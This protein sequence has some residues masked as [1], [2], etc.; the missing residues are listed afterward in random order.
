MFNQNND[1]LLEINDTLENITNVHKYFETL[2]PNLTI[3][4]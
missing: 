3:K 2:S 1:N 4:I